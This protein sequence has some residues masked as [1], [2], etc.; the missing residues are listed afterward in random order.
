[1]WEGLRKLTRWCLQYGVGGWGQRVPGSYMRLMVL[2]WPVAQASASDWSKVAKSDWTAIMSRKRTEQRPVDS[3]ITSSVGEMPP[4][5]ETIIDSTMKVLLPQLS[6]KI[7][8]QVSQAVKSALS[9]TSSSGQRMRWVH[10]EMGKQ[11]K[12]GAKRHVGVL[13]VI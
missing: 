12:V 1:M 11:Q 6:N 13:Q 3:G 5:L 4:S 2:N 7:E 8:Q 10:N 9:A